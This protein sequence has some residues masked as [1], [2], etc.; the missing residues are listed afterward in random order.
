MVLATDAAGNVLE[1]IWP[2][3]AGLGPG[4]PI[5]RLQ[6]QQYSAAVQAGV[7]VDADMTFVARAPDGTTPTF[8]VHAS[9]LLVPPLR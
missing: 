8:T 9:N 7:R 3:L 1:I 5:L 6:L 4:Q 2:A